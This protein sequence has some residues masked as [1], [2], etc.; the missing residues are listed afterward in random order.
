MNIQDELERKK[1]LLESLKDTSNLDTQRVKL[2]ELREIHTDGGLSSRKIIGEQEARVKLIEELHDQSIAETK[3]EI[4]K[5]QAQVDQEIGD[6]V[7]K[8]RE[9]LKAKK[10]TAEARWILDGG[11]KESFKENWPSMQAII[12]RES[13][14]AAL[15][16]DPE[17][18]LTDVIARKRSMLSGL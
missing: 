6:Q 18:D 2:R 11:T 9:E 8:A 7:N 14:L 17:P 12:L 4:E 5:L 10:A 13:A 1:K 16:P 3:A 15:E